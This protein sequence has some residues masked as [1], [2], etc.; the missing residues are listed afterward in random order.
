MISKTPAAEVWLLGAST[1]GLRAVAEFLAQV[2]RRP[3]LGFVYVQHIGVEHQEQLVKLVQKYSS[4][5]AEIARA[6]GCLTEGCVTIISPGERVSIAEGGLVAST[7]LNWSGC[8]RPGIDDLCGELAIGYQQHSGMI[9]FTGMG[10]DGVQ[11]SRAIKHGGGSVWVQTP[12][13]CVAPALPEAVLARGHYDY[14]ADIQDLSNRLNECTNR[15]RLE[16]PG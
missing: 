3:G 10:D 16:V 9:V 1:G 6:G 8:Y 7:D 4:W 11:G 2:N 15:S 5:G 14:C 12:N 13:T